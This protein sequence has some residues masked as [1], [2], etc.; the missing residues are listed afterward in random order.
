[1]T[2]TRKS[3][4]LTP[5]QDTVFAIVKLAKEDKEKNGNDIVTDATIGSLADEN[6]N[7]VAYD[8]VFKHY[9]KIDARTK[10]AYA[11]SFIGN[12]NYRD[13]V[14]K[15]VCQDHCDKLNHSVIAT[16]G[17][18]GAVSM[19]ISNILDKG[20]TVILPDIAWGSYKLMA[21]DNHLNVVNYD[22]FDV[23]DICERII[24]GDYAEQQDPEFMQ[25]GCFSKHIEIM[26][27]D[28]CNHIKTDCVIGSKC[29]ACPFHR[30]TDDSSDKHDGYC[31]CWI[32]KAGFDPSATTRPL[33]K[34]MSGQYIGTKRDDY[35]KSKKY[36]MEDL[37]E[38]DLKRHSDKKHI[39][40]DH[41]ERKWLQIG[42]ATRNED[43][44]KD[45]RHKM[46]GDAYLD[47]A[48]LKDEM[49]NWKFP[50]HF[51]DFETSA[52]ALPF[53]EKMRPYEQIAFQ[54]SHH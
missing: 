53:Y 37:S 24:A 21:N 15:W 2:F 43:V 42:V 36:F 35:I 8:N 22:T 48:G 4:N 3:A 29:F 49:K 33:I 34:E 38:D 40:L 27:N 52:V 1:M 32:E 9:D 10:A 44:L 19:T 20:Q 14:Y 47:I 51:I 23:D 26:S 50:L 16:V 39:G 41:Y 30:K 54:F 13:N 6:G 7:L 12:A 28:Y 5:I 18:S 45:Y 25:G 46:R 17:G 11:A 31:E